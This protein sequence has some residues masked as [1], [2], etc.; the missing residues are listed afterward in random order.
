MKC[1]EPLWLSGK[2]MEW[3]NKQNQKIPGSLPA[4]ATFREKKKNMN[5]CCVNWIQPK[6]EIVVSW[7]NLI[8]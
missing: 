1:G 2:G 5:S 3:E 7:Y 6:A 8:I 4:Q